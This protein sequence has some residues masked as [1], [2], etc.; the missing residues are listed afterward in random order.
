M[1][2]FTFQRGVGAVAAGIIYSCEPVFA[3]VLAFFLPGMI[4]AWAG[5][6]YPDEKLT[7]SLLIG[8]GL[9]LAANLVVQFKP[10]ASVNDAT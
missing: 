5:I 7:A 3:S 8:G 2:M 1:L 9:V 4:S 10:R 6:A